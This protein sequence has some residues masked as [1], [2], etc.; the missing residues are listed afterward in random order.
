MTD[1]KTVKHFNC[2]LNF[3]LTHLLTVRVMPSSY[4]FLEVILFF[5]IDG[6]TMSMLEV[7]P[8]MLLENI[9]F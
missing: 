8:N 3:N 9:E 7:P 5:F 1:F 4:A 2:S 6:L